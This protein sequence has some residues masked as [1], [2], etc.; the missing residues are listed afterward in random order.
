MGNICWICYHSPRRRRPSPGH[1]RTVPVGQTHAHDLTRTKLG[2]HRVVAMSPEGSLAATVSCGTTRIDRVF[3]RPPQPPQTAKWALQVETVNSF[4]W[5]PA[6]SWLSMT[7]ASAVLLQEH[8]LPPDRCDEARVWSRKRGWKALFSP[9][10]QGDKDDNRSW[11]AGVAI[12]VR[13][14]L[15]LA[16][17]TAGLQEPVAQFWDDGF[18]PGRLVAGIVTLLDGVAIAVASGYWFSSQGLKECNLR[19]FSVVCQFASATTLDVIVGGDFQVEPALAQNLECFAMSGLVLK[20]ADRSKTHMHLQV[21][22]T[23]HRLVSDVGE[24]GCSG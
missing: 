23:L 15:G 9:A 19:L 3:A 11:T 5:G 22:K 4:N 17:W 14:S 12:F 20:A 13:D 18:V 16:R 24:R 21:R 8:H 6:K 1:A 2:L 7:V 10:L